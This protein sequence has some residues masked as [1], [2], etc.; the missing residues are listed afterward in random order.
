[1]NIEAYFKSLSSELKSV[2]DRVRHMIADGHWLTDG[3]WKESVLRTAIRRSAPL[4]VSVGRG[5]VISQGYQSS[6]IDILIH[7]N[8][9][10]V[11]YRDGDL[12]FV[13]PAACKAVI[14]V[15]SRLTN[16]NLREA[17]QKLSDIAET[18]KRT[19]G[20]PRRPFIGLFGYESEGVQIEKALDTLMTSANTMES[21]VVD[22]I[23]INP[24]CFVKYWE[25]PPDDMQS[26]HRTWRAYNLPEMAAGY[27][28]HNLLMQ[29]SPGA[30]Q[31]RDGVWFP[32]DSK[33]ANFL[34]SK[35]LR[36]TQ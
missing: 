13:A 14:E 3:E 30:E 34:Q 16:H 28:I 25:I 1:M 4:S 33:E 15:K 9:H 10:P 18:I 12:V 19:R 20:G 26:E 27:F 35:S 8:A 21:R 29:L 11:L 32:E 22:H 24:S 31:S 5:F 17:V 23:V 36:S 7:D 2:K 6:Q